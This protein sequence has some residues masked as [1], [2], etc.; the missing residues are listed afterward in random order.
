MLTGSTSVKSSSATA[1]LRMNRLVTVFLRGA[2]SSTNST[3]EL[4]ASPTAQITAYTTGTA[5]ASGGGS[6]G[7][8]PDALGQPSVGAGAGHDVL[9]RSGPQ[10]DALCIL[11]RTETRSS[12][13]LARGGLRSRG[14][15]QRS[16]LVTGLLREARSCRPL[17]ATAPRTPGL[18][19]GM[20]GGH[21]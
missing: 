7:A 15:D 16:E 11:A 14:P 10:Y 2:R 5:T 17:R 12:P 6:G 8:G 4:P 21:H 19:G 3:A 18:R 20:D 1:R 9:A 13:P